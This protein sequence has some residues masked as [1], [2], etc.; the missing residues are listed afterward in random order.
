MMERNKEAIINIIQQ[1]YIQ[2]IHGNQDISLI[3]SGFHKD[4]TML[5]LKNDRL[6]KVKVDQWLERIKEMKAKHPEI[7]NL[8]TQHTIEFIDYSGSAAVVK[9]KVFKGDL[10]FSSDYMLL[11]QFEKGWKIV[12]KIFAVPD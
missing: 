7:W 10:H 12:S 6:E 8:K 3:Q 4:F 9:I 5:V 1:A 2:G 11:Y